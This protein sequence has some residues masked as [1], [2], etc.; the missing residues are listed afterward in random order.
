MAGFCSVCGTQ[1]VTKMHKEEARTYCPQC[2]RFIYRN[3]MAAVAGIVLNSAKEILLA[4]RA[5]DQTY[6]GHWCIPC[7]HIEW[8]EDIR[9]ALAREMQEETGLE[10]E[11]AKIYEVHSNFHNPESLSVGC[12]FLCRTNGEAQAGDDADALGWFIYYHLPE[13]A[14]PTDR[15]VLDKL[16]A[17]DLLKE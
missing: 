3:P 6:A 11:D 4:R 15:K 13:L 9:Q 14:F 2:R 5:A 1:L 12:W 7:G 10:I 17:E 16:F 8:G